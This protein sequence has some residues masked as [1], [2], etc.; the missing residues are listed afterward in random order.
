MFSDKKFKIGDKCRFNFPAWNWTESANII[1]IN[2]ELK[3]IILE[4]KKE[5]IK[6]FFN[7]KK[8]LI[9]CERR[10]KMNKI[11]IEMFPKTKDAILID[12]WF[13]EEFNKPIFKLL[14]TGKEEQL[15]K[16]AERLEKEEKLEE[17]NLKF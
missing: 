17:K 6:L 12:K 3:Y 11:I 4:N 15:I 10:E 13:G 14:L 2:Y 1:K 5:I 7:N 8:E 16:E 9:N